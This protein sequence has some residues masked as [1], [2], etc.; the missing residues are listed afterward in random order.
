MLTA[1]FGIVCTHFVYDFPVLGLDGLSEHSQRGVDKFF[2]I[3]GWRNK[4]QLPFSSQFE[5][6][7]VRIDLGDALGTVFTVSNKPG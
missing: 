6:L 4:E 3:L 2:D 7:G 1:L 5:P